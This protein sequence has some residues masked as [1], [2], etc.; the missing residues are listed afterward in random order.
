VV[1]REIVMLVRHRHAVVLS[2]GVAL[3]MTVQ[4][5]N[6]Q[7]SSYY[8]YF[9]QY[10]TQNTEFAPDAPYAIE[11]G[12]ITFVTAGDDVN[13][14]YVVKP[15]ITT[16]FLDPDGSNTIFAARTGFADEAAMFAAYPTGWY[17]FHIAGGTLGDDSGLLFRDEDPFFSAEVPAFTPDTF[18]ALQRGVDPASAL[19]VDFYPWTT[20]AAGTFNY[21]AIQL[22]ANDGSY[23]TYFNFDPSTMSFTFDADTLPAGKDMFFVLYYSARQEF[24]SA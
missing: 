24:F 17:D 16:V 12:P 21:S 14:A 9:S 3:A 11:G 4:A 1:Q 20:T 6:A 18:N 10:Y 22:F 15:D 23:S 19:T 5:A 13:N 2:A 7:V 8:L